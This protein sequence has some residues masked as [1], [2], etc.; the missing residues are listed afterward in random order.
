MLRAIVKS[1][2]INTQRINEYWNNFKQDSVFVFT[3][4]YKS[5]DL[6]RTIF[7]AKSHLILMAFKISD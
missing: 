5:C 3:I 7:L 6:N 4:V 1:A 2:E